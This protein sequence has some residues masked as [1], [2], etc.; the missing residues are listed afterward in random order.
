MEN[1][2]L[3]SNVDIPNFGTRNA[4]GTDPNEGGT[5]DADDQGRKPEEEE[6]P[7]MKVD[8]TNKPAFTTFTLAAMKLLQDHFEID[9]VKLDDPQ[10][11]QDVDDLYNFLYRKDMVSYNIWNSFF[12]RL[13]LEL[14]FHE[15]QT[16]IMSKIV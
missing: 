11:L 14:S 5:T 7:E 3:V 9:D 1:P 16:A 6:P 4:G 8:T 12:A 10:L 15:K 2:S 13:F